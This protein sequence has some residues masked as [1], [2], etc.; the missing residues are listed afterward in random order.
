MK[1]KGNKMNYIQINKLGKKLNQA[2]NDLKL[3]QKYGLEDLNN[4]TW[5]N[6]EDWNGDTEYD[7]CDLSGKTGACVPMQVLGND[8]EI[9]VFSVLESVAYKLHG[10]AGA[11]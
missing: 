6:P 7:R 9:Y 2:Q 1:G 4:D 10:L 5:S 3:I 11:Y 8:G